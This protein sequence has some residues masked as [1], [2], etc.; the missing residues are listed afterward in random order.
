M[1][2]TT[3]KP[4]T[5]KAKHNGN[6][7]TPGATIPH[8]F[9]SPADGRGTREDS[10]KAAPGKNGGSNQAGADNDSAP[11][12]EPKFKSAKELLAYIGDQFV[13]LRRNGR[14]PAWAALEDRFMK[15]AHILIDAGMM[16]P[17]EMVQI[18]I[19]IE[20]FR[21]TEAGTGKPPGD[22]LAQW[23]QGIEV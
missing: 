21:K 19:E 5:R 11:V 6:G 20:G 7:H 3:V 23:L 14:S 9:T 22:V 13:R 10:A 8:R 15:N 17:K 18:G 2:R 4:A 1:P 16:S 12:D